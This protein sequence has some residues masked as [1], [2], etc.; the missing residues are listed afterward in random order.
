MYKPGSTVVRL[1]R[2]KKEAAFKRKSTT[3]VF[4]YIISGKAREVRREDELGMAGYAGLYPAGI[5]RNVESLEPTVL[6][7]I[8]VIGGAKRKIT[9]KAFPHQ[10]ISL[11]EYISNNPLKESEPYR[12]SQLMRGEWMG[13]QLLQIKKGASLRHVNKGPGYFLVLRGSAALSFPSRKVTVSRDDIIRIDEGTSY[14]IEGSHADGSALL[15]VS[16]RSS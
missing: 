10:K 3:E 2:L 1:F 7:Q 12:W 14:G 8:F 9:P 5:E 15:L 4:Y 13:V 11:N 16:V 6:L